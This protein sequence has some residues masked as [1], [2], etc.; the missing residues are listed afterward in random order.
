L[1][2]Q[3]AR[4]AIHARE[5]RLDVEQARLQLLGSATRE[6]QENLLTLS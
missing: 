1:R 4:Q 3:L 6:I 5:R 2:N